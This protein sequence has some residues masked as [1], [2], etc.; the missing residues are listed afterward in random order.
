MLPDNWWE[1][2]ALLE[3]YGTDN[4]IPAR[5]NVRSFRTGIRRPDKAASLEPTKGLAGDLLGNANPR[6]L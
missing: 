1:R 6:I 3:R 4:H 2:R 5:E